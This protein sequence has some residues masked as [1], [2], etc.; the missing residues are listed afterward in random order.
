M[1]ATLAATDYNVSMGEFIATNGKAIKL[2]FNRKT[3]QFWAV[4]K[5]SQVVGEDGDQVV[6]CAS[7]I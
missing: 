6:E 3:N 2:W 5:I 1:A 4:T 7:Q